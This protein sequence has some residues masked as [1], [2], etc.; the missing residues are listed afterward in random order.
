MV[1]MRVSVA[2]VQ[3]SDHLSYWNSYGV[4]DVFIATLEFVWS[5]HLSYW[6]SYGVTAIL[7]PLCTLDCLLQNCTHVGTVSVAADYLVCRMQHSFVWIV[8]TD[9]IFVMHAIYANIRCI[10]GLNLFRLRR[11]VHYILN[12][13]GSLSARHELTKCCLALD[14]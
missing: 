11:W 6:N 1:V 3:R 10:Y 14:Q 7:R 13:N 8:H 5:D 12:T 2:V 9:L 4:I